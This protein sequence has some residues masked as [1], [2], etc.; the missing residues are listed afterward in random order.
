[1][2]FSKKS[3]VGCVGQFFDNSYCREVPGWPCSVRGDIIAQLKYF[4]H[5]LKSCSLHNCILLHI[6]CYKPPKCFSY[7][8]CTVW[9]CMEKLFKCRGEKELLLPTLLLALSTDTLGWCLQRYC[10]H[11]FCTVLAHSRCFIH[12][13]FMPLSSLT[14]NPLWLT[15]SCT[16]HFICAN[17]KVSLCYW[18]NNFI[19][20]L[21]LCMPFRLKSVRLF[22]I[23]SSLT[24]TV[25]SELNCSDF[26]TWT[27]P[28]LRR[29]T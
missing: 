27:V 14:L 12:H 3:Y 29:T 21:F 11:T 15:D 24:R 2:F 16:Q 9:I 18:H 7:G 8:F 10:S 4:N 25:T 1:M 20:R 5:M 23:S 13:F 28:S 17:W 19:W 6:F 26:F 22:P